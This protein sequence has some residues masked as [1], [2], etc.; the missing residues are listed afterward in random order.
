MWRGFLVTERSVNKKARRDSL[1]KK[2]C[3]LSVLVD[4]V[5]SFSG[6]LNLPWRTQPFAPGSHSCLRFSQNVSLRYL[7]SQLIRI[8]FFKWVCHAPRWWGISFNLNKKWANKPIILSGNG[9]IKIRLSQSLDFGGKG[10][11]RRFWWN[12]RLARW[13]WARG[14]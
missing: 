14:S 5:F 9:L 2:M 1:A 8:S 6:K 4:F 11:N 3:Y 7:H 12:F 10:W 13:S